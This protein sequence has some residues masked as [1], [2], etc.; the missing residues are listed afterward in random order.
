ML[1]G[2]E[3]I[4]QPDRKKVSHELELS[5]H[6]TEA[7]LVSNQK[8]KEVLKFRAGQ[9][10]VESKPYIKYLGITLDQRLTFK[11]CIINTIKI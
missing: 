3:H 2:H 9:C 4:G 1:F 8:L 10:V 11:E 5:E 6:K 7:V